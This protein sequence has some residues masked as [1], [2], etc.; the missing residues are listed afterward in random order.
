M[1]EIK[2]CFWKIHGSHTAARYCTGVNNG[3]EIK[4]IVFSLDEELTNMFRRH[5]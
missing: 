5:A 1:Q 2:E 3:H 4:T